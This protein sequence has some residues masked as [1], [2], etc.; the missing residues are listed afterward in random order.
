MEVKNRMENR[1]DTYCGLYCDA[2]MIM[3]ANKTDKLEDLA[4]KWNMPA[5]QLKCTG[6]KS[7]VV[8]AFCFKC[9]IKSCAQEKAV[10]FCFQCN[11]YPCPKITDFN[12]DEDPHHSVVLKNLDILKAIGL[13]QWLKDQ[14]VRW[15][16]PGCETRFSWYEKTCKQCGQALYNAE[17]EEKDLAG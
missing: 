9:A 8:S 13:D 4:Q 10:E 7:A 5:D 15:S 14:E 1:Y 2:C 11:E 12:N 17:A 6:C 16:C 3:A